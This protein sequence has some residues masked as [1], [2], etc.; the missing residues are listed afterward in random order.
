MTYGSRFRRGRATMSQVPIRPV[1]AATAVKP[2]NVIVFPAGRNWPI[3]VAQERG[4]FS[5][6]GITVEVATTPGSVFQWTR[7]AMG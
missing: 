2:V 7:L 1:V 3:W 5:G 6:H 4:L